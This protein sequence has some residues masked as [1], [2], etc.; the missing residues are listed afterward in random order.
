MY[1]AEIS[2]A[3][4]RG[5]IGSFVAVM[6]NIGVL[7]SYIT[8]IYWPLWVTAALGAL[9]ALIVW[10]LFALAPRSPY[11]LLVS[12]KDPLIARKELLKIR[13][14]GPHIQN[15]LQDMQLA[16]LAE[17][18]DRKNAVPILELVTIPANRKV[19]LMVVTLQFIQQLT[20]VD[21]ILI[22]LEV[23]LE[24]K[25]SSI[26]FGVGKLAS[27]LLSLFLVDRL[28]RKPLLIFSCIMSGVTLTILGTYFYFRDILNYDLSFY[29]SWFPLTIL[30]IF[31]CSYNIGLGIVPF[32]YGG[33]MYPTR[34]KALGVTF[35]E[36][37]YALPMIIATQ[38]FSVSRE[39]FGVYFPFYIFAICSGFGAVFCALVIIETKGKTLQEIQRELKDNS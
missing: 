25:N 32:I 17:N 4:I 37:M 8:T 20:G 10:P 23:I 22:F 16:A 24:E 12:G 30:I 9:A 35:G 34:I 7:V 29:K 18:E 19:T 13:K 11:H 3:K 1:S 2:H 14:D 38:I 15:E 21:A 5:L 27:C 33:E 6:M 39:Y 36:A 26:I 31:I 28:G